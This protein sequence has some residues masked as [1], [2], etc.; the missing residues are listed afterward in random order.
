MYLQAS[1]MYEEESR[2]SHDD[3][4]VAGSETVPIQNI[5][6]GPKQPRSPKRKSTA[7]GSTAARRKSPRLDSIPQKKTQKLTLNEDCH[8]LLPF[9][10]SYDIRT[11][12]S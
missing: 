9:C 1:L 2:Y 10:S 7:Q 12:F 8:V 6:K 5:S 3:E 11:G 4:V